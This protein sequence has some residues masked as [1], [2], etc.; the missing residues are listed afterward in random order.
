MQF[1]GADIEA[2]NSLGERIAN[3]G[4]RNLLELLPDEFTLDDA[5]RVR[6]QQGKDEQKTIFMIRNWMNRNYVI[7]NSEF[8]FEKSYKYKSKN[9]K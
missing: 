8:S 9:N 5:R 6:K 3:R 2:A 7:Q 1:F 4:P